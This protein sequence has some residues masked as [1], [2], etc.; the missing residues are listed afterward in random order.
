MDPRISIDTK[1]PDY[2]SASHEEIDGVEYVLFKINK[3]DKRQVDMWQTDMIKFFQDQR[4]KGKTT[5]IYM[6]DI[7]DIRYAISKHHAI[8]AL[9][10]MGVGE[11]L[12]MKNVFIFVILPQNNKKGLLTR[13]ISSV[14][15]IINVY[16]NERY[17]FICEFV[18]DINEGRRRVLEVIE[19][20]CS[21][22]QT[23][24]V[25]V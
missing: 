21:E 14:A 13:A 5:A 15:Q 22:E 18:D 24:K 25:D 11:D 1:H 7:T 20:V 4:K 6:L 19:K 2:Y 10:I 12:G 8:T 3:S 17:K 16:S 9:Q 23:H